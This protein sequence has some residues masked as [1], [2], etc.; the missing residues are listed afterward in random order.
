VTPSKRRIVLTC[1]QALSMPY[2]TL[3]FVHL[4]WRVI[5]IEPG[6]I[7]GRKSKGDPN[8][9]IGR[10]LPGVAED[11]HGYFVGPNV[12][13]EAIVI[14]LKKPEG[15]T[16]LHR[17]VRELGA[18]VFC[19]N[20]MPGHHKTLGYDYETLRAVKP[21]LIW[22]SISAMG[23]AHPEVPGYDPVMQALCGYMDL[24]GYPDGS[25]LQCGPPLTDLKAG[26]EVFA[27]TML[28]LMERAETGQGRMI[29]ISMAQVAVSWLHTFLPMLDLG[30]PPSELRRSANEH[31]Q[32]IPTNAYPS[33]DGFVY[34]AIGSDAQWAR[35][36][37]EPMFSSLDQP[38]YQ[39]NEGR[40]ENKVELHRSIGEITKKHAVDEISKA[41]TAAGIPHA[42]ITPIEKVPDLPFVKATA[43]RTITPGGQTVRLPPPA[44]STPWLEQVDRCIPFAPGYGEHTDQVLGEAGLSKDEIG[45]LRS[46]GIVY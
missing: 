12:G 24:T 11:R 14:D 8:R 31:R 28:G 27:Q 15:R 45:Q 1:E 6:P 10:L 13:K 25:P 39:T 3:R 18:D 16:L 30:S 36:A 42:P 32:F 40:R 23:T 21:D 5:R 20:T 22:A 17:L 41:L 9:Y 4:G 7:P 46:G 35:I 37:K 26:D 34:M 38:R 43:L 44:V 33:A 2:A 29:D 19:T